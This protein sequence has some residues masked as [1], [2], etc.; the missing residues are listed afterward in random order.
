LRTTAGRIVTARKW[1]NIQQGWTPE[2]DTLP[3]RFLTEKLGEG[4]SQG[5]VISKKQLD[6]L[7]EKYNLARGWTQEG[8]L[9]DE[10]LEKLG[11]TTI[12]TTSPM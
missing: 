11:F 3:K 6:R 2:E 9:G 1:Y 12:S 10:Y 7:I 5:A 4:A 8:W